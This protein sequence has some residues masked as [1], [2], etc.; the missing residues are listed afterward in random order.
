M[1]GR[2]ILYDIPFVLGG[3]G[4]YCSDRFCSGV[5]PLVLGETPG[6]SLNI[7]RVYSIL[8]AAF[9]AMAHRVTPTD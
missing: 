3:Y 9:W 4:R 8:C 1:H 7:F 6:L 5:C 2:S